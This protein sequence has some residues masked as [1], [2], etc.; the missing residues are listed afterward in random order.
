MKAKEMEKSKPEIEL[1]EKEIKTHLANYSEEDISK[2]YTESIKEFK[3]D[4]IVKGKV[5]NVTD[6]D[7]VLNLG[8][9][10]EGL[11]A[12]SEFGADEKFTPGDEI[13]VF[14]DEVD[15]DAGILVISKNRADRQRSWE[16]IVNNYK[17]GSVIHGRVMTQTRGG[18]IIDVEGTQA[19]MPSSQVDIHKTDDFRDL[20]RKEIDC[21]VIKIDHAQ[22]SIIVSRRQHLEEQREIMKQKLL[23]E[24]KEGDVL[25]G[26]VKN[27]VDFGVFVDIKGVEGLL[28][29]S[30]MSWGRISHP[31]EVVALNQEIGVKVLKVEI[32]KGRFSLGMKQLTE[33]P[34]EKVA[35]KYPASTKIK[36]K[37]VNIVPY[38]VFVEVEHGV[39]GLL[40]ISEMSWTKRLTHPSEMVAIGDIIEA[41]VLK[42]DPGN[43]EISLGMKQLEE[44][45]WSEIEKKY[46]A[47]T[48]I[49]GRVKNIT[50]YG[51]FIE[52][53]EGVDGLLHA[54]DMLW[55]KKFVKPSD[56]VK[57]GD[58][59]EAVILSV[60][61]DKKRVS[62]GLKQ[63]TPNPWETIFLEKYPEN[64]VVPA[65]VI[66]LTTHGA[67]VQLEVNLE[68]TVDIPKTDE[69]VKAGDTINVQIVKLDAA[70][71]RVVLKMPEVIAQG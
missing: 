64:A 71:C 31:S 42:S 14:I 24:I 6:K 17:E 8:Y 69:V 57:K 56:V 65:K 1:I 61:P 3:P 49:Q 62:L 5:V 35:S 26:V 23:A 15:D 4:T 51:A 25:K 63:L 12:K 22:R 30:D 54:G 36:G 43:Q 39:E 11:L 41:I 47:E 46:P 53:E 27:I 52:I 16:R 44:N 45:P 13:E 9:K 70:E 19:F 60:D 34:W 58:K 32:E 50:S 68:G 7:V 55:T 10:S 2:I 48:K 21:K 20:L 66:K 37:V 18:L 67:V 59:I 33:N 28:H 38:G 29:I 40:H